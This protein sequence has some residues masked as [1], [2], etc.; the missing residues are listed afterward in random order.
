MYAEIKM[1]LTSDVLDCYKICNEY[2]LHEFTPNVF[3]EIQK[4]R[5]MICIHLSIF[6]PRGW[7]HT[8]GVRQ[9]K[10]IKTLGIR[11]DTSAEVLI[12]VLGL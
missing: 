3:C 6:S 5:I 8:R 9:P 7:G 12:G 11:L 1:I 2:I 10:N 4:S